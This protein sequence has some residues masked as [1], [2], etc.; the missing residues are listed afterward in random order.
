L[1]DHMAT[2]CGYLNEYRGLKPEIQ[3][4]LSPKFF[5]YITSVCWRKNHRRINH[6]AAVDLVI[7]LMYISWDNLH[8]ET[9]IAEFPDTGVDRKLAT[10]LTNMVKHEPLAIASVIKFDPS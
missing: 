7:Q 10:E 5:S 3:G 6:W 9:A 8:M 1:T 2:V 4:K